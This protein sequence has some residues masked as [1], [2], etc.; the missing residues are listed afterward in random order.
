M[1]F[2]SSVKRHKVQLMSS[3]ML[4]IRNIYFEK[5]FLNSSSKHK[6]GS[7]CIHGSMRFQPLLSISFTRLL[8]ATLEICPEVKLNIPKSE[9]L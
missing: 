6:F 1:P 5:R 7:A 3:L 8:L 2:L 4:I 9:L